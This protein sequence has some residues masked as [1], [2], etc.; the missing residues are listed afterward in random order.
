MAKLNPAKRD[1]ELY[2]NN[3]KVIQARYKDGI[4]SNLDLGDAQLA[5]L[6]S[7]FNH[8]QYLYDCLSAKAKLDKAMGVEIK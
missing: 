7:Q 6:I 4:A 8:R 2:E 1:I 5:F 3:V